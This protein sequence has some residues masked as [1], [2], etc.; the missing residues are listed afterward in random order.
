MADGMKTNGRQK[1][2]KLILSKAYG[3]DGI[4]QKI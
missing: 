3:G 2:D 4:G 1:R